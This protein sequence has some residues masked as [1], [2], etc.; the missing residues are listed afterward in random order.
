KPRATVQMRRALEH[1]SEH[2]LAIMWHEG[3][4]GGLARPN[5]ARLGDTARC[6]SYP[7]LLR[8]GTIEARPRR[9]GGDMPQ[10][11]L[12]AVGAPRVLAVR[13]R[14]LMIGEGLVQRG[15]ADLDHLETR[16]AFEHPVA[17]VRWL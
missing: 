3:D 4:R 14:Q 7:R 12:P 11:L 9:L 15:R 10:E 13:Q 8:F 5:D 17:D 2:Q 6:L 1:E 16:R